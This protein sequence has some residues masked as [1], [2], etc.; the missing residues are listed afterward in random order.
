MAKKSRKHKLEATAPS[1]PEKTLSS[2]HTQILFILLFALVGF[3]HLQN[4]TGRKLIEYDDHRHIAPMLKLS[5]KEYFTTWLPQRNNYAYPVRDMLYFA[6]DSLNQIVGFQTFIFFQVIFFALTLLVFRRILLLYFAEKTIV[7]PTL[8]LWAAHPLVVEPLQ[9]IWIQKNILAFLFLLMASY[10]VLKKHRQQTAM[11]SKQWWQVSGLWLLSLGCWPTGTL[12]P[13]FPMWLQRQHLPRQKLYNLSAS[14]GFLIFLYLHMVTNGE[15]DY[16]PAATSVFTNLPMTFSYAVNSFGRGFYSFFLPHHLAIYYQ[17]NH[18]YAW[19]GLG[20]GT[21]FLYLLYRTIVRHNE[22]KPVLTLLLLALICFA[23]QALAFLGYSSFIWADRYMYVMVPFL[24]L[25]FVVLAKQKIKNAALIYF[26]VPALTYFS[27]ERVPFWYD[28]LTLTQDCVDLENSPRCINLLLEKLYDRKGCA[29]AY[30]YLIKLSEAYPKATHWDNFLRAEVPF[31][32]ALCA[33]EVQAPAQEKIAEISA[34]FKTYNG[35]PHLISGLFL[36]QLEQGE[37]EKAWDSFKN[38][39]VMVTNQA[40]PSTYK[41]NIIYGGMLKAYC[42][43][44]QSAECYQHFEEYMQANKKSMIENSTQFITGYQK[45][46]NA[47][48]KPR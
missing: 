21:A 1:E 46:L 41:L 11:S 47:L 19:V 2:R 22:L 38:L 10:V 5:L 44:T 33:A 24:S 13:V 34:L 42:E 3:V 43:S 15:R 26:L 4:S 35:N 27:Y 31:Y 17:L 20:L 25:S 8:F 18:T 23:P 39:I 32:H 9:W 37:H 28:D 45:V 40:S 29:T 12:W 6:E 48:H 16:Q 7:W 14:F 30:P 36:A